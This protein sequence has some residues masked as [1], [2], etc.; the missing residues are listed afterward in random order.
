MRNGF[1]LLIVPALACGAAPHIDPGSVTFV[2][3]AASRVV[4]TTYRLVGDAAIV[5]MGV[6]TNAGGDVWIDI[7]AE[8]VTRLAGP[9]NRVVQPDPVVDRVVKWCP[10]LDWPDM[11]FSGGK[12]R[13]VFTA[14][15]TNDPPPYMAVDLSTSNAVRYYASEAALPFGVSNRLW[16]TEMMLMRRIRAAGVEW[17]MGAPTN[18]PGGAGTISPSVAAG[19]AWALETPHRVTLTR[20]YYIGV[21]PVT[22]FQWTR[23][24]NAG[25]A[26]LTS[27]ESGDVELHPMDR[28]PWARLA[29]DDDSLVVRM[30]SVSGLAG[31]AVPTCAEWE[32]ACRAGARTGLYTGEELELSQSQ[33]N[34]PYDVPSERLGRIA[35]YKNNSGKRTHAVGGKLPNAWGLYDMLG[36]V[37][38]LT[39]DYHKV[40]FGAED[41]VD[42]EYATPQDRTYQ[43]TCGGQFNR[44]AYRVR[45]SCRNAYSNPGA[46]D[47]VGCRLIC[48]IY[49]N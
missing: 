39:R 43:S 42:P 36:N 48:Y 24:M 9:V 30:R 25:G 32:F 23:A 27:C 10:D 11:S 1:L 34:S 28:T 29:G 19:W 26:D 49:G 13:A 12:A 46:A 3:D 18:E 31:F 47:C 22:Q 20:D 14:W 15:P 40:D 6:E 5:T 35:W 37:D 16:K 4:T 2:Q 45:C 17:C 8:R 44:D 7:G 33:L 41:Q 21:Y 38:E